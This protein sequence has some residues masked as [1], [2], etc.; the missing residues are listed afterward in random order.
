[1]P[2]N[3]EQAELQALGA[4]IADFEGDG[5][6]SKKLEY[7]KH[8]YAGF[9]RSEAAVLTDVKLSTINR[10]IKNDPRVAH[11]D[12]LVSTG[13]RRELRK[14]VLEEE[15][16]RNFHLV[17]LQD[18]HILK[19]A[20][21][22]LEE[23]VTEILPNGKTRR[24]TICPP[25]TKADWDRFG[26]MRKMYNMDAWATIEKV[27]KGEDKNFNIASVIMNIQNNHHAPA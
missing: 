6:D 26:Q 14:E 7:L 17:I 1:M 16:Y 5:Q 11:F 4:L 23:E 19:K 15:W 27:V 12:N 21:G 22:L 9:R 24:V 2:A 20:S 13:N 18:A 3:P 8:R 10:W 25:M